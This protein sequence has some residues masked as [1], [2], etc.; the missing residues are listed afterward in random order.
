MAKNNAN[1]SLP[2][3]IPY[4]PL[5]TKVSYQTPL[6]KRFPWMPLGDSAL[7]L[8]CEFVCCQSVYVLFLSGLDL[9]RVP[10]FGSSRT[11]FPVSGRFD[12]RRMNDRWKIHWASCSL[13]LDLSHH[14]VL[15]ATTW[16][17]RCA[18][19]MQNLSRNGWVSMVQFIVYTFSIPS[20][21]LQLFRN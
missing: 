17:L 15:G 20:I 16:M 8:M 7:L 1:T 3:I 21:K 14:C 13:I 18:D 12:W 10:F 6:A 11:V 4:F 5:S 19:F 2:L 9:N